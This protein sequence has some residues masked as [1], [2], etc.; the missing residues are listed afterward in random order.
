MISQLNLVDFTYEEMC[1]YLVDSIIGRLSLVKFCWQM[2]CVIPKSGKE[3]AI[4]EQLNL[5]SSIQSSGFREG[6]KPS[7]SLND[8]CVPRVLLPL[9]AMQCMA[10]MASRLSGFL[11]WLTLTR[12]NHDATSQRSFGGVN[13]AADGQLKLIENVALHSFGKGRLKL[14][15]FYRAGKRHGR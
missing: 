10:K 3:Y 13:L 12:E 2:Y 15:N 4:S 5:A 11:S 6:K 14:S 9:P 1:S 8:M 7:N